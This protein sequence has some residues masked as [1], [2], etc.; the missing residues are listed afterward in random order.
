MYVYDNK[1]EKDYK[2]IANFK[3]PPKGIIIFDSYN[4]DWFPIK[5]VKIDP[6]LL[7][8]EESFEFFVIPAIISLAP[9]A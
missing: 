4:N 2:S 8:G 6:A 9:S 1:A 5:A 3:R 7:K